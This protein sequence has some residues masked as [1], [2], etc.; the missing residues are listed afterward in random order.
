MYG[1]TVGSRTR[2]W[3]IATAFLAITL[4]IGLNAQSAAAQPTPL[5][6]DP[7]VVDPTSCG[8]FETQA[9]AQAAFDSGDLPDPENLDAD[10]DGIVCEFRWGEIHGGP[11]V[12]DRVS[13]GH[14]ETQAD[15]QAYFDETELEDPSVLDW[16]GDGIACE[17][18]FDEDY[19]EPVVV[20]CGHFESREEA[21][22]AIERGNV[23]YPE[24]LEPGPGR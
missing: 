9:D 10:G 11:T 8:H 24:D 15:A 7:V 18:A 19:N 21:V 12:I 2:T 17:E 6:G 22:E 5:P 23:A 20:D 3:W 1:T 14:F 13:C 4:M 16:D